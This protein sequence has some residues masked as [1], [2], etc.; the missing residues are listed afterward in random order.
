MMMRMLESGGVPPLIDGFRS[1][2]DDNPLGYYEFEAVKRLDKMPTTRQ[3][4]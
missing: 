2:D 1:A 3:S 4:R